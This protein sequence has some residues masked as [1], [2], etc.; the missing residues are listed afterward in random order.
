[1]LPRGV[2]LNNPGN[3]R[4]GTT[5]WRGKIAGDDP[6][7]E[8]FISPKYGIRAIAK[9]LLSYQDKYGIRTVAD[10]INRWAPPVEND[11]QAYI[12]HV[13]AKLGVRP[14]EPLDFHREAILLPLVMAIIRHE[15]GEQ[16]YDAETLKDAVQDAL[17]P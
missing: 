14:Y 16:P 3:I 8:T 2:R 6:D 7:F 11:T 5:Q 10:A 12:N 15:N 1:M 4:K 17:A 9:T 13:A